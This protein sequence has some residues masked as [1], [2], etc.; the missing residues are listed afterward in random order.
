VDFLS[1]FTI[2]SPPAQTQSPPIEDLLAVVLLV[3]NKVKE[4]HCARVI[5]RGPTI[6]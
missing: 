6:I 5:G 2:V 4:N 3:R 1:N